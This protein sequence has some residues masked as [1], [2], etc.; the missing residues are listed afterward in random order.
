LQNMNTL[1][2]FTEASQEG[3]TYD[4]YWATG[5]KVKGVVRTHIARTEDARMAAEMAVANHLLV[6]RNVSGHHKTGNGLVITFSGGVVRKLL[7]EKSDKHYLSRYANFLRTRFLGCEVLVENRR[8]VWVG[9]ECLE[10]FEELHV[11]EAAVCHID[12]PA[13]GPCEVTAHAVEQFQ[14]RFGLAP[15]N[16]WRKLNKIAPT[17]RPQAPLPRNVRHDMKHRQTGSRYVTASGELALVV[18]PP[19]RPGRRP[20]I[21][22]VL[23]LGAGCC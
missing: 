11:S 3:M 7:R 8:E 23:A 4:T 6:N 1:R 19:V 13:I 12:I 5:E 18:T 2:L 21:V 14:E 17:L 22:T 10:D 9:P 15:E 16:I 20:S